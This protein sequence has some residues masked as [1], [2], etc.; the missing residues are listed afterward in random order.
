MFKKLLSSVFGTEPPPQA[1]TFDE[2]RWEEAIR[3]GRAFFDK[4]KHSR[5]I[6][7]YSACL[8]DDMPDIRRQE[9]L[10]LLAVANLHDGR[11]EEA[12]R[13]F[14]EVVR[15]TE[16]VGGQ[17]FELVSTLNLWAKSLEAR[18]EA[19]AAEPI[20]QRHRAVTAALADYMWET[21]DATGDVIHRAIGIRFPASFRGY[22]RTGLSFER[23]DGTS[24]IVYYEVPSPHRSNATIKLQVSD[25]RPEV[26]LA[27]L[28]DEAVWWLGVTDASYQQGHFVAGNGPDAPIGIR[29]LWPI[30]EK[31]GASWVLETF[32]VPFGQLHIRFFVT[33][34]VGEFDPDDIRTLLA[35]FD[36][37]R[38]DG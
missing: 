21:D 2:A 19:A 16:A 1:E 23:N 14:S 24:G 9:T 3:T 33:H 35:E 25:L 27:G 38:A 34:V 7:W 20:R 18:G 11:H 36:W 26:G 4:D 37:P 32:F 17:Q 5:A 10:Y 30:I 13:L 6:Q 8:T 29:R 15:L 12:E 31:D 28:A 22:Q